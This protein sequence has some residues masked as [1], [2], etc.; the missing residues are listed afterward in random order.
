MTS[1][2]ENDLATVAASPAFK[3]VKPLLEEVLG[4]SLKPLNELTQR[5]RRKQWGDRS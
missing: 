2:D 1:Q 3:R 5:V 4:V